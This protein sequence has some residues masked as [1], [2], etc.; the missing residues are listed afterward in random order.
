MATEEVNYITGKTRPPEDMQR[1]AAVAHELDVPK[2]DTMYNFFRAIDGYYGLTAKIPEKIEHSGKR[3]V[4]AVEQAAAIHAEKALQSETARSIADQRKMMEVVIERVAK[5]A[6]AYA[7]TAYKFRAWAMGGV[8]ICVV[9]WMAFGY[10]IIHSTARFY[11]A[12]QVLDNTKGMKVFQLKDH[13]VAGV[14]VDQ[15]VYDGKSILY[16][17]ASDKASDM[18]VGWLKRNS[19][20]DNPAIV[21]IIGGLIG[22]ISTLIFVYSHNIMLAGER[23]VGTV[24]GWF[25][26]EKEG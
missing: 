19:K 13:V 14:E 22:I 15:A 7:P 6:Q 11:A 20:T 21:A 9:A 1:L 16:V 8:V 26:K 10:G 3:V 5:E 23:L 17:P 25:T 12:K 4:A 24:K 2:H 18:T